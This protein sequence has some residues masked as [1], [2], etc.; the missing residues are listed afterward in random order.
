MLIMFL[1]YTVYMRGTAAKV[2]KAHAASI[3]GFEVC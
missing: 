3:L 2:S 1:G